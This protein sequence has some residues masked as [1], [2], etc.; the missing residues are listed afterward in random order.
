VAKIKLNEARRELHRANADLNYFL[1]L[2][3]DELAKRNKYKVHSG[4]DAICF[5]LA[6]KYSWTPAQVRGMSYDDLRFMLD[7]EMR[8]WTVPKNA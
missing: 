1:D 3:G 6:N 4:M 2:F 5:Y 8:G 7:E